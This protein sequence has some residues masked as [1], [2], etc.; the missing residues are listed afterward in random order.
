MKINLSSNFFRTIIDGSNAEGDLSNDA[1]GSSNKLMAQ[2]RLPKGF[3]AQL[4][5][6]YRTPITVP[7]GSI[8]AMYWSDIS[9]KKKY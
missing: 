4:S 6:M 5:G 9:V 1:L 8:D 3:S 7:Q 2:F